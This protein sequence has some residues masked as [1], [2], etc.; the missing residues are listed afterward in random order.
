MTDPGSVPLP[1]NAWEWLQRL[2]CLCV[3]GTRPEAIKMAPVIST[4]KRSTWAHPFVVATGQHE[5][6]V[7]AALAEFGLSADTTLTLRREGRSLNSVLS[8]AIDKLDQLAETLSPACVIA[9]G[10][11]TSVAAAALVAFHR[12]LPLIHVEAGLRTG[13]PLAPFPEEINRRLT[14]LVAALHCAPTESAAENLLREG[15]N[16]NDIL[17]SG[18]TV[19]DA[20]FETVAKPLSVPAGF[21]ET[22]KTI[23]VTAHRRESFDGG[24]ESAFWGLRAVVEKHQ[25][26]GLFFP[27]HPNPNTR[28]PAR[29]ILGDH[30]RISLVEP[31]GYSD[32]VSAMNRSWLVVTDSGGIQEEAPALGRPVLVLRNV[33]ER[34]EAV[35]SGAV[36]LIGTE[37]E[38]VSKSVSDLIDDPSLYH[39]MS[40][41]IFPYG[42]GFAAGR[43]VDAIQERLV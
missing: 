9:Q 30:P 28:E 43:I 12:K 5:D 14:G 25:D 35:S 21:P 11:T 2:S 18:N 13:N 24:L 29:R 23:L 1:G 39:K 34:P 7:D 17:I 20:L 27:V 4:L 33:T 38:K 8:Q 26:I 3:V 10:D 31:L 19:I 6:L 42:D 40:V 36:R 15:V 37:R 32:L 22:A 41:P 16:R